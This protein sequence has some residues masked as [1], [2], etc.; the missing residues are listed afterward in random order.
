MK[1]DY[2]RENYNAGAY[3]MPRTNAQMV[4][5]IVKKLLFAIFIILVA[6]YFNACVPMVLGIKDIE[7]GDTT[8][9][10]ITGGDVSASLN[11]VDTVDNNR[12]INPDA[13]ALKGKQQ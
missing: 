3:K 12:G 10:F 5:D 7:S 11:G 1:T 8:I 6:C 2:N 4:D 13:K 9:H